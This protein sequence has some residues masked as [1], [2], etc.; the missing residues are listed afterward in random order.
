[1]KEKLCA[2]I[3]IVTG[4]RTLE[5]SGYA[6]GPHWVLTAYH[7]LFDD[8]LDLTNDT[9]VIITWPAADPIN[10]KLPSEKVTRQK[11]KWADK[12]SDLALIECPLPEG[13]VQTADELL[14][15]SAP[16]NESS[17]R[18]YG[19]LSELE[20]SEGNRDAHG[21]KGTFG[22]SNKNKEAIPV[23]VTVGALDDAGLWAGFS[24]APLFVRNKLSAIAVFSKP[25]HRG[26]GLGAVS[27]WKALELE[28]EEGRSL[29]DLL[30]INLEED[31]A[32]RLNKWFKPLLL[33]KISQSDVVKDQAINVFCDL[34]SEDSVV[35]EVSL[36]DALL[37]STP[38]ECV[39][40][41]E[42]LFE[43]FHEDWTAESKLAIH[44][45][46]ILLLSKVFPDRGAIRVIKDSRN[47]GEK[48]I[49]CN[50]ANLLD[51]EVA[52][53]LADGQPANVKFKKERAHYPYHVGSGSRRTGL[54]P[55]ASEAVKDI[56][57]NI[58]TKTTPGQ[59]INVVGELWSEAFPGDSGDLVA[60]LENPKDKLRL[61][62]K[63]SHKSAR[64]YYVCL[65]HDS[66]DEQH[67]ECLK[68]WFDSLDLIK[69]K[70][71]S[72]P[73]V[74]ELLMDMDAIIR[75]TASGKSDD[76]QK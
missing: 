66:T 60:S 11:I 45:L 48:I 36:A 7:V 76:N 18:S 46:A 8:E 21:P 50:T 44:E 2:E 64:R 5:G 58:I 27:V 52:L 68:D 47:S 57:H 31:Y 30:G 53:S 75:K 22:F 69:M 10:G 6:I 29:A 20:D 62:V 4:G 40:F 59:I 43:S 73:L 67:F 70:P 38:E 17:W 49:D 72:D 23:T 37:Q 12:T 19:F 39:V 61:L 42:R 51:T 25:G 56:S 13:T 63:K 14:Q 28:N 35:D 55:M 74:T 71:Y 24:G 54:D 41:M 32:D 33:K 65:P 26:A 1:M 3:S 9:Q 15:R 16:V 34:H